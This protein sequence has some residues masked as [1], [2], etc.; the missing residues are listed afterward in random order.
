VIAYTDALTLTRATEP[1]DWSEH[2]IAALP[3]LQP[4]EPGGI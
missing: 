4:S 1:A 3:R 2:R